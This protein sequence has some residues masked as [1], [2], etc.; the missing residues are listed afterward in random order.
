MSRAGCR[1]PRAARIRSDQ[2]A[3]ELRS[4]ARSRGRW[5]V[6][7]RCGNDLGYARVLIRVAKHVM[8]SAVARNRMRR[9]IREVF[10]HERSRLPAFDYF[11]AL[12]HPYKEASLDPARRELA[13]LLQ[14]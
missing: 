3:E 1:L 9:C 2:R 7:R 10:R 5:F 12:I 11:I 13:R 6:L 8:A 4:A 14:T